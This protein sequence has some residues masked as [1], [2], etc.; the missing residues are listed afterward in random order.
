MD[1]KNC[2]QLTDAYREPQTLKRALSHLRR[3]ATAGFSNTSFL[4]LDPRKAARLKQQLVDRGFKTGLFSYYS[5]P[6]KLTL[7][8]EW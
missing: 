6:K 4:F 1:A 7:E 8:V 2:R 5:D 3:M